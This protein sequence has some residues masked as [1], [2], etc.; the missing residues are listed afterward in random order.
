MAADSRTA[1][2]RS[3]R[4][5]SALGASARPQASARVSA[6]EGASDAREPSASGSQP[7]DTP[8]FIDAESASAGT[9][10]RGVLKRGSRGQA[11]GR[12]SRDATSCRRSPDGRLSPSPAGGSAGA[13]PQRGGVRHR[14]PPSARSIPRAARRSHPAGIPRRASSARPRGAARPAA[15]AHPCAF[16]ARRRTRARRRRGA[17]GV[18][19]SE[20]TYRFAPHPAGGFLLGLRIPQLLG[21]I[22]AGALALGAL[23]LGG[24]G[25][26][27]LALRLARAR[28][29]CAAGPG[30]WADARAVGAGDAC[31]SCSAATARR[32]R[33]R[34]QRAQLGHLVA[35][36]TG[37]LDPQR[38]QRAVVAARRS[39][40]SS[41]S[42]RAS[43]CATS[44]RASAS[45]KDARARTFTAALRVRGRAFALLGPEERE[46][47]LAGLRRGARRARARRQSPCA[48]S[49]GSSARSPATATRSATTC[50][51]PSAR[52]RRFEDPPEELVSYL[53]LIG[54]AGDVAEEHELLFALQVD[55]Q[56]ARPRAARSRGWAAETS[57]RSR[58]SP[59]R[60][61]S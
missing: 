50:S 46:Q 8:A 5:R 56:R 29:R 9:H 55:A 49:A 58:C 12:R 44:T 13:P 61:G 4:R 52:T 28:R 36:P 2:C 57:A 17:G 23:R 35:L 15:G 25:G 51:R 54:R 30:A 20:T 41:S 48:A 32:A 43:S 42:S 27:A 38:P 31:G 7:Q 16:A 60:S 1:R 10:W 53:Q 3:P 26:L 21:F 22:L 19:V 6:A 45:V 18:A 47:R 59:G 34:A 40:R 24:L 39:S 37:G 11:A 14:S 33:F